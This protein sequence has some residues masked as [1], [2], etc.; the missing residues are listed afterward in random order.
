MGS[1]AAKP[2]PGLVGTRQTFSVKT[3]LGHCGGSRLGLEKAWEIWKEQGD[4]EGLLCSQGGENKICVSVES[5]LNLEH[6]PP[7]T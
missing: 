1:V 2:K 3:V 6:T 4:G 7:G 5:C